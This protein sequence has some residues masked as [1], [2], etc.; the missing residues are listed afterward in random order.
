MFNFEFLS[1]VGGAS[2]L[3]IVGMIACFLYIMFFMLNIRFS[4]LVKGAAHK[5]IKFTGKKVKAKED[6]FSREYAI[7]LV[8]EKNNRYKMY[9]FL[10]EL[11]IDLGLKPQGITPYELLL[12]MTLASILGAIAF[13][14]VV[15]NSV[16]LGIIA[17]PIVFAGVVCGCYTK[18]NLAHDRRI[19]AVIEAENIICNNIKGGVR[20]A[21]ESSYDAL[22]IE[23]KSE[24]KDFL[25]NI[26]DMMYITTALDDL[27][28]KLGAVSDEFIEKCKKFELDEEHGTVGIFQDL[29]EINGIKTNLRLQMKKSFEEVVYEFV[30]SA[31]MIIAFLIGVLVVFPYVR[32]IYLNTLIGQIIILLDALIFTGEFVFITYL[33]AKEL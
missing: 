28:N 29:V 20:L 25:N 22:P 4:E 10:N 24:F 2:A 1:S 13:G 16:V 33:R 6:K 19:E 15:F 26:S 3:A 9:R 31:V 14:V 5:T 11:T 32:N 21:V 12:F 27:N 23:V 18:A 30:V 17:F 8:T 7:G